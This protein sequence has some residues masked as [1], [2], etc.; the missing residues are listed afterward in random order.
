MHTG[1]RI[2][3]ESFGV[4]LLMAWVVILTVTHQTTLSSSQI[5]TV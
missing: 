4:I 5:E 1:L 2:K 3:L